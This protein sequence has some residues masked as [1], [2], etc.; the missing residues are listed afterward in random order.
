MISSAGSPRPELPFGPAGQDRV[1]VGLC[2]AG[3]HAGCYV[4]Y[5]SYFSS[6]PDWYLF[7]FA[8]PECMV[9]LQD[10]DYSFFAEDKP[11]MEQKL[12]E[13][14]VAWYSGR[15]AEA[16]MFEHFPSQRPEE[17]GTLQRFTDWI[18]RRLP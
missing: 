16:V 3:S 4:L 2:R 7:E 15:E 14:D 13:L 1:S 9:E 6:T 18:W 12:D 5:F 11:E 8:G 17:P 10:S